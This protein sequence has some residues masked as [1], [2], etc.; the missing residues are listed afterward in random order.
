MGRIRRLWVGEKLVQF[1]NVW[2]SVRG[3]SV[4]FR[5]VS[6][7]PISGWPTKTHSSTL[8]I[9][10]H[11]QYHPTLCRRKNVNRTM[12]SDTDF[13]AYSRSEQSL[14]KQLPLPYSNEVEEDIHHNNM[15]SAFR[16]IKTLAGQKQSQPVLSSIHKADGTPC[17]CNEEILSL[18]HI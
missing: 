10:G 12:L 17:R 15:R 7:V 3:C 13:K 8:V 14:P 4:R 6:T 9:R 1:R 16:A 5:V 18:I 2:V 11:L